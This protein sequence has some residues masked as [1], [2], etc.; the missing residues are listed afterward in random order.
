MKNDALLELLKRFWKPIVFS[1]ASVIS[2]TVAHITISISI[3]FIHIGDVNIHT[4]ISP[5]QEAESKEGTNPPSHPGAERATIQLEDL[6]HCTTYEF[7]ASLDPDFKDAK[8]ITF[9][10][11][12]DESGR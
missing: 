1:G 11:L 6:E 7:Q 3:D 2:I 10:T 12:C 8:S 5:V 4:V 9:T